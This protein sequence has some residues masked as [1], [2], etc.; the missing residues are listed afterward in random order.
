MATYSSVTA[1]KNAI[2]KKTRQAMQEVSNKGR[3]SAEKNVNGFYVGEPII[4]KRTGK[5]RESPE[6]NGVSGGGSSVQTEIYL[7]DDYSYNTGTWS[8]PQVMDAAEYGTGNLVGQPG[9]WKNTKAEIPDI[10][11]SAFTGVGFTKK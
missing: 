2:R 9:F 11:D 7:N 10:I 8:T 6:T 5:L 1:I 4:Y 3:E